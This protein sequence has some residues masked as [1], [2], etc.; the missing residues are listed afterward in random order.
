MRNILI[1]LTALFFGGCS[2][3]VGAEMTSKEECEKLMN[4]ILPAAEQML[5]RYGEF[6]PFGGTMD[7]NGKVS[8]IA[9]YE[10]NEHPLSQTVIDLLTQGFQSDAKAGKI[11]A[12]AII[13]DMRVTLPG[14]N[15]KTDAIC[16]QLDHKDGYTVEVFFPYTIDGNKEVRL[17]KAF[18]QR[19][20]GLIWSVK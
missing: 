3:R 13:Y 20:K 4:V 12:T 8:L 11:K 18:A 9:A 7:L 10:G 5:A 1:I 2:L 6:Y 16:I 17:Q 14:S 19:G 15:V